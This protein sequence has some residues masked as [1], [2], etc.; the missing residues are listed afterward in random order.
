MPHDFAAKAEFRGKGHFY[1]DFEIGRFREM[2]RE[3]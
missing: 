1:E 2:I 3:A